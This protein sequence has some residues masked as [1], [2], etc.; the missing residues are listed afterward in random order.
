VRRD[1]G[2]RVAGEQFDLGREWTR[3]AQS[4]I[5]FR[6]RARFDRHHDELLAG[7]QR[8]SPTVRQSQVDRAGRGAATRDPDVFARRRS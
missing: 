7:E 6:T 4:S 5:R 2:A 3:T 8:S 1:R